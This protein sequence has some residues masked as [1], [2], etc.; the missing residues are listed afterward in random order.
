MTVSNERLD[1]MLSPCPFCGGKV[2]MTDLNDEDDR[3]MWVRYVECETC[4]LKMRGWTGWPAKGIPFNR[5][6]LSDKVAVSLSAA[7]NRR[8]SPSGVEVKASEMDEED[9]ASDD[10]WNAGVNYAIERLCEIFGI[11]PKT[12]SWDA[13][14]ETLDGDVMS[15]LCN[16]L[17]AAYGE[18]WSS[19]H[20]TTAAVR[21]Y[22]D[23]E[24]SSSALTPGG[25]ERYGSSDPDADRQIREL[26]NTISSLQGTLQEAS[27]IVS[28]PIPTGEAEPVAWLCEDVVMPQNTNVTLNKDFAAGRAKYPDAWIITPLFTSP[29]PNGVAVSDEM[30]ERLA[31]EL[32]ALADV[33]VDTD[34]KLVR[35]EAATSMLR[36]AKSLRR[37]AWVSDAAL[38]QSALGALEELA[39]MPLG[40]SMDDWCRVSAPIL[41][42]LEGGSQ[43]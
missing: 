21:A 12:I 29:V 28:P 7:W 24:T 25:K 17:V 10:R 39:N 22:L 42:A 19:G 1:E 31:D 4:D 32:E 26:L 41:A 20:S 27:Q 18:E 23:A 2:T 43:T 36:A 30:V 13:A 37:K 38:K 11:D 6:D 40:I 34:G 33:I 35:V 16:V 8:A 3:R 15:V 9:L 5:D 14:T